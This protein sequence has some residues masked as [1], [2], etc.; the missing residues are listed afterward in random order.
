LGDESVQRKA[1][2]GSGARVV[3]VS[4]H[5]GRFLRGLLSCKAPETAGAKSFGRAELGRQ[6]AEAKPQRGYDA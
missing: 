5:L 4:A 1:L 6:W 2:P 3:M